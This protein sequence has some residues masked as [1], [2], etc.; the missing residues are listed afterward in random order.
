M[1]FGLYWRYSLARTAESVTPVKAKFHYSGKL[2]SGQEGGA[3]AFD[4]RRP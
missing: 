2:Q 4:C 3:D 1:E